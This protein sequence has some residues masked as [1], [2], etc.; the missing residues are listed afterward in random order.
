MINQDLLERVLTAKEERANYQKTLISKY[1][2]P[3]IS[4]TLN[5]PGGYLQY[6][7]WDLVF[8][9]AVRNIDNI[10]SEN[11]MFRKVKLG[12]WGPEGF[13]VVDLFVQDIKKKTIEIEDN[14]P[15]GRLFDIDVIDIDA[16]P[17]SRRDFNIEPRKCIICNNKALECYIEKKHTQKEIKNKVNEII[18]KGLK[19]YGK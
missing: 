8:Q 9:E 7:K 1:K 17:V 5:L 13:W 6:I 10:F 12:E 19:L 4:L 2:L 18:E 16:T 3:L 14:H 15:L 11:I